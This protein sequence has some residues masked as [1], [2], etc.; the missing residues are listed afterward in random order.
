MV[1]GPILKYSMYHIN[2]IQGLISVLILYDIVL[3]QYRGQRVFFNDMSSFEL[4][5]GFL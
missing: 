4:A 2:A 1:S 5:I 3:G